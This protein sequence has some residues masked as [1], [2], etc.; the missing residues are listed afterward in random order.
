MIIKKERNRGN[1]ICAVAYLVNRHVCSNRAC[2]LPKPLIKCFKDWWA[3]SKPL[4]LNCSRDY[5][6]VLQPRV[7]HLILWRNLY[8]NDL[9]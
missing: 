2:Y 6:F 4:P 1:R 8:V 7:K 9:S 5:H 3:R